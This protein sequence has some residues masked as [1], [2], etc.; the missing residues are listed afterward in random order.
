M[1]TATKILNDHELERVLNFQ[2]QK[3]VEI[4]LATGCFDVI[5][6]GHIKLLE[7]AAEHGILFVGVN[8]DESVR[9]LKGPT[10]P[11]NNEQDRMVV[12]AGLE[13]V[14]GVFLIRGT[15]VAEAI[16]KV[17]PSAWVKGSGYTLDTLNKEEVAAANEVGADIVLVPVVEGKSSTSVINKM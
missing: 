4:A 2:H 12:L 13:C 11:I 9:K 14:Q 3:G 8:D 10:R 17:R 5:H 15:D 1:N 6:K 16:R 7:S